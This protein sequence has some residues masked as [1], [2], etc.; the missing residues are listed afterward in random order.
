[1]KLFYVYWSYFLLND[2]ASF[3]L[4]CFS[5]DSGSFFLLVLLQRGKNI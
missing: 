1:L 2:F 4:A 3:S 5:V